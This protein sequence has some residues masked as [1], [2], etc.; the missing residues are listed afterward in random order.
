MKS[1]IFILIVGISG[2]YLWLN[3]AGKIDEIGLTQLAQKAKNSAS[4]L[5]QS[6]QQTM[7]GQDWSIESIRQG[8]QEAMNV[9]V[10]E[11]E[12]Q[13]RQAQQHNTELRAQ[14]ASLQPSSV[15]RSAINGDD[16][17]KEV[18]A[19]RP[20]S[21]VLLGSTNSTHADETDPASRRQALIALTDRM[22]LRSVGN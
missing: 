1:L 21:P 14:L 5:S 6:A 18:V 4:D 11:L 16:H 2:T 3:Q 20:V 10:S 7:E 13:L 8:I 12:E 17:I 9:R 19:D 22:I 15:P